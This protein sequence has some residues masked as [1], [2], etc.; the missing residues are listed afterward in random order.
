[1]KEVTVMKIAKFFAAVFALLGCTFFLSTA[2]VC[3]ASL[4]SSVW[5]VKLPE[6]AVECSEELMDAVN[7]GD[8]EAVSEL[9]YGQPD[10]GA[11]REPEEE[12]GQMIWDAFQNSICMEL[13]GECYAE[14]SEI[15]RNGT[16][17]ALDIP[18]LAEAFQSRF[19]AL[20]TARMEAA[21]QMEELY[22][23]NSN[24]RKELV[25]EVRDEAL[26]QVLQ[27]HDHLVSR[28]ITLKLIR[29]DGRWWVVPD[30]ALLTAISGGVA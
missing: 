8:Y 30:G 7:T 13:T 23:E 22:D 21:T 11:D 12:M 10:F 28:E 9:L 29:R 3:F 24:F 15:L 1:M 5:M 4:D 19:H 20:L 18:S 14:N 26:K 6:G 25:E 27:E 16:I 2:V 17:T